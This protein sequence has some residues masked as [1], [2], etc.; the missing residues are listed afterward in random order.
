MNW[1]P[2]LV[3]T[4]F[5][6]K[7]RYI[8]TG[9]TVKV[10]FESKILPN[11]NLEEVVKIGEKSNWLLTWKDGESKYFIDIA[12]LNSSHYKPSKNLKIGYR[13]EGG[14]HPKREASNKILD[15][16]QENFKW[17]KKN[18]LK[19]NL[20][21]KSIKKEWDLNLTH[22]NHKLRS[23][24]I[25]IRLSGRLRGIEK[26]KSLTL[27]KGSIRM[28]SFNSKIDYAR[29]DIITKW[30]VWGMKIYLAV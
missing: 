17:N 18:N 22:K 5:Q 14:S 29:K 8:W 30:G 7:E 4:T 13:G 10:P 1:V 21:H 11:I 6:D 12:N 16:S 23:T 19:E 26:A 20:I 3:K 15:I 2:L 9:K 25:L 28:Q 24:G 27:K